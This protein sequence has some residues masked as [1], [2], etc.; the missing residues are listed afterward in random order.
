MLSKLER[1][2]ITRADERRLE[3]DLGDRTPL[4]EEML[5][6]RVGFSDCALFYRD[7]ALYLPELMNAFYVPVHMRQ[8]H[9]SRY[10]ASETITPIFCCTAGRRVVIHSFGNAKAKP[11]HQN[12]YVTKYTI[13]W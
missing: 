9:T 5:L 2:V 8:S 4:T 6:E 10:Y 3:G 12:S 7:H 11:F 13:E 1:Q